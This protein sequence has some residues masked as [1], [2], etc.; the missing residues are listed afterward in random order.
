MG[1]H[2]VLTADRAGVIPTA[3]T[4]NIGTRIVLR[5]AGE[6]EY[7]AAGV[8]ADILDHSA[9]GRAVVNG[10]ELQVAVPGGVA[11]LSAQ[12]TRIEA[13]AVRL[14]EAGLPDAEP[15]ERLAG[16]IPSSDLPA[17]VAGRPGFGVDDETLGPVGI[18]LDGLFVV[19]GPFGSGR[20]TAMT[21]AIRAF[22]V[23]HPEFAAYLLVARKSALAGAT[24]WTEASTD[25]DD[26]EALASRLATLLE[27]S[28]AMPL[29][30]LI[31][32][33]ENIGDFEGL[34][35]E[36][37]VARLL[38][39]ARRAGVPVLAEAD[40]VTAP[41][42]WQVYSELKTARAGIV[43]QPEESDGLGLFRV[44]FPRVTRTDFP[45]GRGILVDSGKLARVQ[46]AWSGPIA[47]DR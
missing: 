11:D 45:V 20:S 19:T 15:V 29:D 2:I 22:R 4:A 14:R 6:S 36:S 10:Y 9:G 32:V 42:A 17:T 35:A 7:A 25:A 28:S 43:L 1:I 21:T 27:Q 16:F 47:I 13:L 5:L 37:Q 46:V 3:F 26:A 34:S 41:A 44:P 12:S 23:A 30:P 33:I 38:K 8:D 31:I 18:P 39:A 24:A 40:T